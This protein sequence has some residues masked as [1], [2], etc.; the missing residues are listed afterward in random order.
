MYGGVRGVGLAAVRGE[1]VDWK[2]KGREMVSRAGGSCLFF[3]TYCRCN[4]SN[5]AGGMETCVETPL[6]V[7]GIKRKIL[8]FKK[9][10][11]PHRS[12][13]TED[14]EFSFQSGQLRVKT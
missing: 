6:S 1:G 7:N 9:A 8:L 3:F 14:A 11:G 10:Y 12:R 4:S 13:R 5:V 2:K